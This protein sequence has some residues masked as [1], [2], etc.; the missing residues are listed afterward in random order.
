MRRGTENVIEE[1][2]IEIGIDQGDPV[3]ILGDLGHAQGIERDQE[4][5]GVVIG[6]F[7]NVNLMCRVS[8]Q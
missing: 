8:M 2:G 3:P 4:E 5:A 1:T 7:L 6:Q